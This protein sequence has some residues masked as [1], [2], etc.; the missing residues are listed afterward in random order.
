MSSM[1][2]I[3]WSHWILAGALAWTP[4]AG[5]AEPV[6]EHR[7][8]APGPCAE[9]RNAAAGSEPVYNTAADEEASQGDD[10]EVAGDPRQHFTPVDVAG[11]PSDVYLPPEPPGFLRS[12]CDGPDAG[13]AGAF[14]GIG[15]GETG[16]GLVE[17]P[18]VSSGPPGTGQ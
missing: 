1:I 8:A 11:G 16:V 7:L 9:P 13:C 3:R 17:S 4:L 12:P 14:S 2:A 10:F 5:L 15:G 18:A 6:G